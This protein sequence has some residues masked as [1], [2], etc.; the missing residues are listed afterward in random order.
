MMKMLLA[1]PILLMMLVVPPME[2]MPRRIIGM[3]ATNSILTI[4][5]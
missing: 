3:V 2:T 4:S 1:R 5:L